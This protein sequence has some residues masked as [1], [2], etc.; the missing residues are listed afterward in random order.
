MHSTKEA[1]TQV[2][3]LE[4]KFS[5]ENAVVLA[6]QLQ[7]LLK[8]E[9]KTHKQFLV[10]ILA[11][12]LLLGLGATVEAQ[13]PPQT[14]DLTFW[15]NVQDSGI[16]DGIRITGTVANPVT[17]QQAE[18]FQKSWNATHC[19]TPLQVDTEGRKIIDLVYAVRAGT[20]VSV[21]E[22]SSFEGKYPGEPE[23][24]L[25]N[26]LTPTI[27]TLNAR[28]KEAQIPMVLRV[29]L[30][31]IEGSSNDQKN[32]G[33][34]KDPFREIST[35][36][37]CNAQTAGLHFDD[38]NGFYQAANSSGYYTST[39]PV[40]LNNG[41]TFEVTIPRDAALAHELNHYIFGLADE[42]FADVDLNWLRDSL[43][44][45][46]Q[47]RSQE[48][49]LFSES[50][51]EKMAHQTLTEFSQDETVV[52]SAENQVLTANS[53][54][55]DTLE[56]TAGLGK[57][58]DWFFKT[59]DTELC[60][61]LFTRCLQEQGL[62]DT[63]LKESNGKRD[64]NTYSDYSQL[65][66]L[67]RVLYP[68]LWHPGPRLPL[69]LLPK[70][71][72][73]SFLNKQ[74]PPGAQLNIYRSNIDGNRDILQKMATYQMNGTEVTVA[75]P[76]E[77]ISYYLDL[78][79]DQAA[80]LFLKIT[81]ADGK[82]LYYSWLDA[83]STIA[84]SY[85]NHDGSFALDKLNKPPQQ[86]TIQMLLA[87]LNE[88][89]DQS[90]F[91]FRAQENGDPAT[92][93]QELR[94]QGTVP[95]F[96]SEGMLAPQYKVSADELA[97]NM[98]QLQIFGS[99]TTPL[100]QQEI[101]AIRVSYDTQPH[102]KVTDTLRT[103]AVYVPQDQADSFFQQNNLQNNTEQEKIQALV[104]YVLEH[105]KII[106][107][108]LEQSQLKTRIEL[109][110]LVFVQN[111]I[112][113]TGLTEWYAA[114]NQSFA[115]TVSQLTF[116]TSYFFSPN[117]EF[118]QQF[119][120]IL[121]EQI[122]RFLGDPTPAFSTDSFT[123]QLLRAMD[124]TSIIVPIRISDPDL[125]AAADPYEP[126][127]NNFHRGVI[128]T[129]ELQPGTNS[130]IE[131][132]E[133]LGFRAEQLPDTVTFTIKNAPANATYSL[134]LH[135]DVKDVSGEKIQFVPLEQGQTFTREQLTAVMQQ[136]EN[137]YYSFGN[138]I[139]VTINFPDLKNRQR[140]MYRFIST[141]EILGE[142]APASQGGELSLFFFAFYGDSGQ[143]LP[144]TV[145]DTR[146]HID[147]KYTGGQPVQAVPDAPIQNKFQ[148][149]PL[150]QR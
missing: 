58:A 14:P 26:F 111:G 7:K 30:F 49:P 116:K 75:N 124:G 76:W 59:P 31:V 6:I 138:G 73:F 137:G 84:M 11:M 142:M 149:L 147:S 95:T 144:F 150:I 16:Q 35:D 127:F 114:D 48:I 109:T 69:Q 136:D 63:P 125:A 92:F 62:M 47:A 97:A 10:F 21:T 43:N 87:E 104:R 51:L 140:T 27:T 121:C 53:V 113:Q 22:G 17:L 88:P 143:H 12:S 3:P 120:H 70:E 37:L 50:N 91:G 141:K 148:F 20:V 131:G 23:K 34:T 99:L 13:T 139:L 46:T 60:S 64:I 82:P 98:G 78:R 101:D 126:H 38:G 57:K 105:Q 110:K 24:D 90:K 42:Y 61:P 39:F 45:H 100:S 8:R 123:T 56:A 122:F 93:P 112:N 9:S 71:I 80:T 132:R 65:E 83:T 18:A 15:Q 94:D 108:T 117:T 33:Y 52:H 118:S 1:V 96:F 68:D 128:A 102:P 2:T 134:Y 19:E 28:L 32:P 67:W 5:I 89:L 77:D 40:I 54:F 29:S 74:I 79:L 36:S 129:R 41:Q 25:L 66:L 145:R 72:K 107:T 103:Y 81:G 55:S 4:N 133:A 85:K 115:D 146:Y 44:P 86:T 135:K 119:L 130:T 106:N